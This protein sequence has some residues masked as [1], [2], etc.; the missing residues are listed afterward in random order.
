MQYQEK[1]YASHGMGRLHQTVVDIYR[2]CKHA[3]Q[4]N[5]S[6]GMLAVNL[7]SPLD[8]TVIPNVVL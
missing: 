6:A 5:S 8:N 4:G 2:D 1:I 3:P 7:I